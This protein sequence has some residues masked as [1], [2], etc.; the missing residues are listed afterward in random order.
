MATSRTPDQFV[1]RMRILAKA[2]EK[3]TLETV[4]RAA[5]AAD[6]VLV[7]RTPVETGRARANWLV[8]VGSPRTETTE[9][10]SRSA[11]LNE[12]RS[13]ISDYK[14]GQG[15][16]FIANNLSYISLLDAGSS[17]KAPNG[18]TAAALVAARKRFVD[19]K[20]LDGA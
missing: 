17:K 7:L 10:T 11:A 3:N 5:I 12:G 14:L 9:S 2:V 18:M 1:R 19:A 6:Q 13:V 20:L 4:R 16:I 8:S 15:G